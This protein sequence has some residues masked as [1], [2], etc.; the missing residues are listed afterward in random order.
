MYDIIVIEKLTV[1]TVIGVY[2][3]EKRIQQRLVF[4]V[5]MVWDNQQAIATDNVEHC[6]NYAAVSDAII[7][8]MQNRTFALIETA[9]H[10]LAEH[11]MQK[12]SIPW[13]RLKLSKP[14]AVAQAKNVAVIIEKGKR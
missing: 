3:W 2:D 12:F 1:F 13:L 8:F 7:A 14:D 6:L 9:A 10:Q 4:D 11:L 5:E